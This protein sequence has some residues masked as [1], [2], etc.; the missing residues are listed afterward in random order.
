MG[1][2]VRFH[3]DDFVWVQVRAL[4]TAVRLT[5]QSDL[6]PSPTIDNEWVIPPINLGGLGQQV[7]EPA[8]SIGNLGQRLAGIAHRLW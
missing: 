8:Y 3:E 4:D 7:G 5:A 2:R 1:V 6:Q